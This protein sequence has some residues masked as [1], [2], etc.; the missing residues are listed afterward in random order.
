M[1]LYYES[2]ETN[3]EVPVAIPTNLEAT[4]SHS[5][6]PSN[7]LNPFVNYQYVEAQTELTEEKYDEP[8]SDIKVIKLT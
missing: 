2:K 8:P 7:S 3:Q 6:N 5:L 1:R 4:T